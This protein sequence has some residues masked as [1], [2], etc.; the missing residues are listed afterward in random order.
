IARALANDPAILLADEPT[1]G[2][3]QQSMDVVL[4]LFAELRHGRGL[5]V[6]MVS[7]DP[8]VLAQSDRSLILRDGR[9]EQ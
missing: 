3:D 8:R 9:L 6:L 2:L 5:T 1:G 4:S 7:H